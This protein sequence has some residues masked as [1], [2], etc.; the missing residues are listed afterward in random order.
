M[1]Q[2]PDLGLLQKQLSRYRILYLVA[3]NKKQRWLASL[4][5][6]SSVSKNLT[7]SITTS[8]TTNF[9][10]ID[11]QHWYKNKYRHA[12]IFTEVINSSIT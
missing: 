7:I 11:F 3:F 4:T 1:A 5:H 10:Y 8:I 12:P 2:H 6:Y 9:K